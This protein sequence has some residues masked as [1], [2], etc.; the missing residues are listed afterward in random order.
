MKAFV[1]GGQGFIGKNL[2]QRLQHDGHDVT[3][4]DRKDGNNILNIVEMT[5]AMGAAGTTIVFHLAARADL[6]L[7]LTETSYVYENNTI[8]T[9]NVLEA[10]KKNKVKR[11]VF[12]STGSVYGEPDIFPTP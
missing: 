9:F 10:M 2:V 1:T 3:I 12:A 4:W 7:N 8:G 6:R 5:E 11:I